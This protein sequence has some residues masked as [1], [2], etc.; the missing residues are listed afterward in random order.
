MPTPLK[1]LLA[2]STLAFAQGCATATVIAKATGFEKQ[3]SSSSLT[4]WQ[5]TGARQT[6]L[7]VDL[8]YVAPPPPPAPAPAPAP[9]VPPPAP[10]APPRPVVVVP[11]PPWPGPIVVAPPGPPPPRPSPPPLPPPEPAP[12]P[13]PELPPAVVVAV[14]AAPPSARLVC[15]LESRFS[16]A[17]YRTER[18]LYEPSHKLLIGF[19]GLSESALAAT[20]LAFSER[21]DGSLDATALAMG[22]LLGLDAV[23]TWAL[24]GHPKRNFVEEYDAP[25]PVETVGSCPEGMSVVV[26]GVRSEV[27]PDG[28]VHPEVGARLYEAM[29]YPGSSFSF[30]V[31]GAARTVEPTQAQ[32]CRFAEVNHL[33]PPVGCPVWWVIPEPGW[34]LELGP[35]APPVTSSSS[36]SHG[37]SGR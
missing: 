12:L 31:G 33:P 14:P 37:T 18:W 3:V 16:M 1:T 25:G 29:R 5:P 6:T 20:A 34:A 9:P 4:T 17:H 15:R 27:A 36:A 22:I 13:P 19:F 10:P 7:R 21:K 30:A 8:A 26:G 11:A 23:G 28:S 2:L 24:L 32:R 35:T